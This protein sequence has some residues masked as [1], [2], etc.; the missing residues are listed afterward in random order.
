VFDARGRLVRTLLRGESRSAAEHRA[1]WDGLDGY[2][3]AA[4]SGT[5][6]FR[7]RAGGFDQVVKGALVR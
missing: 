1:V 3:N 4:P 7:V 6:L 2:G 5:Y